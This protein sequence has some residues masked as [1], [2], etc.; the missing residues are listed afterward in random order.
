MEG[1]RSGLD[2]SLARIEK[3]RAFDNLAR[4]MEGWTEKTGGL[5]IDA[6]DYPELMRQ[7]GILD[8]RN[9]APAK[10]QE[11]IREWM[12]TDARWKEARAE[13][14]KFVELVG[15]FDGER[16]EHE[17]KCV[18]AGRLLPTPSRLRLG[19]KQVCR[20]AERLESRMDTGER[21][22]H[23]RAAGKDPDSLDSTVREIHNWL[24]VQERMQRKSLSL[25]HDGISM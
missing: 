13:V 1:V 6:P 4:K 19:A 20:T 12:D 16:K 7:A 17:A 14:E 25:D 3:V 23:I 11:T 24:A 22:A 21:N 8:E 2:S 5:E 9:G 10:D 18:E 15:R